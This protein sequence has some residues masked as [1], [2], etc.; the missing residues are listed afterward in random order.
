MS[1]YSEYFDMIAAY[2]PCIHRGDEGVCSFIAGSILRTQSRKALLMHYDF[3]VIDKQ[4]GYRPKPDAKHVTGKTGRILKKVLTDLSDYDLEIVVANFNTHFLVDTD[5]WTLTVNKDFLDGFTGKFQKEV[6]F[7]TTDDCKSQYSSCMRYDYVDNDG[8]PEHPCEAYNTPDFEIAILKDE[9]GV[10]LARAV[11]CTRNKTRGPIYTVNS[12]AYSEMES[13]LEE[14]GV[15]VA[16]NGDWVGA[17]LKTVEYDSDDATAYCGYRL[18]PYLDVSPSH[19]LL[20][21]ETGYSVIK[22]KSSRYSYPAVSASGIVNYRR[23]LVE[24]K[25][26]DKTEVNST[27]QVMSWN[28]LSMRY[29]SLIESAGSV[30]T[31]NT[32]N[33]L[34]GFYGRRL[35]EIV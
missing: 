1:S 15:G 17:R 13:R 7:E 8:Y 27:A 31:S 5:G 30:S 28:E 25:A 4:L 32:R 9:N 29:S 21:S 33:N 19:I 10:N 26:E 22:D 6:N 20:D 18:L 3:R 16:Q 23:I 24:D 14:K 12:K 11:I 2:G 34:Y 35:N